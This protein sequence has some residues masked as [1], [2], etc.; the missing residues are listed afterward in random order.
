[1]NK[2][3]KKT[4]VKGTIN[5]KNVLKFNPGQVKISS[6]YITLDFLRHLQDARKTDD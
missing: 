6:K 1:M 5:T 3:T 2:Q 4:N